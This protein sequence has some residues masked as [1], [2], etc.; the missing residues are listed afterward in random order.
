MLVGYA[1]VSTIEQETRLQ[2]DALQRA[3]VKRIFTEKASSVGPRPQLRR[4]LSCLET[5]DVLVVWKMDRIARNLK[6]LLLLLEQMDR[7][8]CRFR[9]LTE[10]VDTSN[11]LGEFMV[12]I[13]GAVAQL[14][15]A[16]IRERVLAGQVAAYRRGVRWGGSAPRLTDGQVRELKRLKAQ[17]WRAEDLAERYSLGKSSIYR[18]LAPP[19]ESARQRLRVLGPLVA[20]SGEG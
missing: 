16:M 9:S 7:R 19:V 8:G 10:P 20:R 14:E 2:L 11:A 13:L 1:R 6:D 12:Q 3:G 18:Y 4:A 17:G 5:G 15:R